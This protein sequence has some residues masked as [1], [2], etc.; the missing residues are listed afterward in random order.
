MDYPVKRNL[1]GVF[2]RMERNNKFENIDFADMTQ[3]E[4]DT[5]L[6]KYDRETL[7]R[8]C[9]ILGKCIQDIGNYFN[10]ECGEED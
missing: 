5:V 4:M 9:K 6:E 8:M 1:S 7:I 2:Y 3:S 10:I